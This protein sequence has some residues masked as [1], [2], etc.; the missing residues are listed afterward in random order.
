MSSNSKTGFNWLFFMCVICFFLFLG[1]KL[2]EVG[3]VASWSWWWV[4]APIWGYFALGFSIILMFVIIC[5]V[6]Y[7]CSW[8]GD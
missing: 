8:R 2:A 4:T 3:T 5:L 1:L 6:A 7:L